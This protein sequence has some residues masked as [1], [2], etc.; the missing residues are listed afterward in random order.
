MRLIITRPAADAARTM[1]LLSSAGHEPV[2]FPLLEV[3][4]V[5]APAQAAIRSA[6][7]SL[8]QADFAA[9]V[10]PNAARF[11]LPHLD[12]WPAHVYALATG[13]GTAGVLR[14]MGITRVLVPESDFSSEGVVAVLASTPMR[15]KRVV[16]F[17]GEAGRDFL[18]ETLTAQGAQVEAVVSYRR[19]P[20]SPTSVQWQDLLRRAPDAWQLTS[21]EAV[22]HL[23]HQLDDRPELHHLRN[24]PA[25]VSHPRI[26]Q[27]AHEAGFATIRLTRPGDAGLMEALRASPVASSAS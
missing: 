20:V 2:A 13:P 22:R 9:F 26:G 19:A 21:S 1:S 27:A 3:G 5:D 24:L 23:G 18:A 12:A 6:A 4:P 11:A 25:Y 16:L 15:G 8:N 7:A 17:R 14:G 10:S